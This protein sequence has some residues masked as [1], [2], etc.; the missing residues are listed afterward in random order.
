MREFV[1]LPT[2]WITDQEDP[3]LRRFKWDGADNAGKVAALMLYIAIAHHVNEKPNEV[4]PRPGFARLS[5]SDF[6]KIV[7]L[8]R[9][10]IA[11]GLKILEA[12]RIV[13]V[14][15]EEKT[16]VY[17]LVGYNPAG[18]WAKLP[19]GY[20]YQDD[21]I[22]A[23][24]DFHLRRKNELNAL[25]M[26]LLAVAFRDNKSN[27]TIIAYENIHR[28]TGIPEND[29]RSAISLLINLRLI[30]VDRASEPMEDGE[31]WTVKN[32]NLYRLMGLR[33][34][35]LGNTSRDDLQQHIEAN[36]LD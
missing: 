13:A 23:F 18:R 35:H 19:C 15:K 14:N 12:L 28:Y 33:G 6:E 32:K 9:A 30:Q 26:Y 29:I 7:G 34:R 8:S 22:R 36:P 27:Y 20:L 3:G 21:R 4:F 16:S 10:K 24:G 17:Q 31:L 5:Y 1:K 2:S 11:A 25:K